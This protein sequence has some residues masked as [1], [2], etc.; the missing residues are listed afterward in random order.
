VEG[1]ARV[2]VS[3]QKRTTSSVNLMIQD[4]AKILA[5]DPSYLSSFTLIICTNIDPSVE[6]RIA[7][8]LWDSPLISHLM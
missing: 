5:T 6:L 8:L 4:P 2:D 3:L 7:D 1:A